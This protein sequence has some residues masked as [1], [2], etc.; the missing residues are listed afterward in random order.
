MEVD[1]VAHCGDVAAGSFANTLVLTDIASGW[2]ECI[3]LI[4]REGA[5]VVDAIDRLRDT[6]PFVLRGIDTDNGSEFV[7]EV[8]FAYCNEKKIEFTP[9]AAVPG[10]TTKR[11]SSRRMARSS[12]GWLATDDSKA[13]PP[14]MR[15]RGYILRRDCL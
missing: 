7:N 11:G 14:A 3:A 4:V 15:S 5:L 10:R 12:A 1:L 2:T 9:I 6:M 8:L 13:L